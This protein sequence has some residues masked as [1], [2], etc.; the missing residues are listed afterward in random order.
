MINAIV[1]QAAALILS[2]AWVP[3]V[4]RFYRQW[5]ARKNPVSLG[6][7]LSMITIAYGDVVL[8][9][10]YHGL[11]LTFGRAIWISVQFL[12]CTYFYVAFWISDTR[13]K[14]TREEDLVIEEPADPKS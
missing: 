4:L 10:F 6:I 14:G 8:V 12:S 13:Y 3:I 5:K 11:D 1:L 7:F 9:M 2:L